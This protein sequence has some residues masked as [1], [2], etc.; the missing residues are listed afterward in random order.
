MLNSTVSVLWFFSNANE[1][2]SHNLQGLFNFTFISQFL[3][4]GTF[5]VFINRV[6]TVHNLGIAGVVLAKWERNI[7]T[8]EV[9]LNEIL[10]I[11][12]GFQ[13]INDCM[14]ACMDSKF[15]TSSLT[16]LPYKEKFSPAIPVKYYPMYRSTKIRHST[17]VFDFPHSK[18]RNTLL[19]SGERLDSLLELFDSNFAQMR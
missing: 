1:I 2:F 6:P 19:E 9:Y 10:T 15:G 11:F 17:E 3:L 8:I 13:F 4:R 14:Y 7:N 5:S 16:T 12:E 18:K